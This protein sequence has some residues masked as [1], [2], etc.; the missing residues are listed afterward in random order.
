MP[1]FP[2]SVTVDF[3]CYQRSGDNL[4]WPRYPN[5]DKPFP[6]IF[7][8]AAVDAQGSGTLTSPKPLAGSASVATAVTAALTTGGG[9]G[10]TRFWNP[11]LWGDANTVVFNGQTVASR[12]SSELSIVKARADCIGYCMFITWAAIETAQDVYQFSQFDDC[13]NS[14]AAAGKRMLVIPEVGA[15]SSSHPGTTDASILPLYLQQ[16]PATY[17]QAGY[18]VAGVVTTVS[19]RSGWYGGDGNGT[20]YAAQL[21]NT[22]VGNRF[23]KLIQAIAN[24]ANSKPLFDGIIFGENSFWVGANSDNGGG[25]SYSDAKATA[26]QNALIQASVAAFTKANVV[27]ENTF[28]QT[29]T[30]TQ[31]LENSLIQEK[32]MPG[33]TDLY[34][35]MYITY[36]NSPSGTV[37]GWGQQAYAGQL[38]PGSTAPITNWKAQGVRFL[39]EI[40]APDL[41]AYSGVA[42]GTF[43]FPF[44]S[45]PNVGDTTSQVSPSFNGGKWPNGSNYNVRFSDGSSRKGTVSDG[46]TFV[47]SAAISA[48]G[49][50]NI[51]ICHMGGTDGFTPQDLAD[52]YNLD[53]GAAYVL[54]TVI[55]DNAT[56]LP[57]DRRWTNVMNVLTVNKPATAYPTN[58]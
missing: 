46:K 25:A 17:G 28:M 27:Y 52:S 10:H 3:A 19:G 7:G 57:V 23:I 33:Q 39:T 26:T 13:Y 54:M 50:T 43:N 32:A 58:Y 29:V 22:N 24:W 1:S 51:G 2:P 35:H 34:G 56:Y 4:F 30:P 16:D 38:G 11:G 41:G 31:V 45:A 12:I 9:G 44:A 48:S 8:Q 18:R 40:Q 20:T 5:G 6:G 37:F 47:W 42:G 15:F 55:P 36:R 49:L 53:Y 14:L 21:H